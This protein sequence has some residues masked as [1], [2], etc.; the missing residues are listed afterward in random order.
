MS[1][2]DKIPIRLNSMKKIF[3]RLFTTV[4]ENQAKAYTL[5]YREKKL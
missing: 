3:I 2:D 1:T 4:D 5:R